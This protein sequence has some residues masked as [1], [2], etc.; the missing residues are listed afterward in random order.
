MESETTCPVR[1]TSMH[2]FIAVTLGFWLIID[3]KFTKPTSNI[4][5]KNKDRFLFYYFI[6]IIIII[7]IIITSAC[8]GGGCVF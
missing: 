4:T 2:E 5:K 3:T 7:I 1:S 6:I 8:H